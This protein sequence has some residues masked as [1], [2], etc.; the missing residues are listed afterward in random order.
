MANE[1]PLDFSSTNP[2]GTVG[3]VPGKE[4]IT[5]N[6]KTEDTTSTSLTLTGKGQANYGEH[7]QE[8]LLKL[9][10]NFA[11]PTEPS[12]ATIGQLWW[13]TLDPVKPSLMV[14]KSISP[15]VWVPVGDPMIR[16]AY[17]YE[18]NRM[19]ELYQRIVGDVTIGTNCSDSYGWGQPTMAAAVPKIFL[20]ANPAL[21]P[22]WVFLLNKWKNIAPV[23]GV[24]PSR[25][26]SD[27]FI[28]DDHYHIEEGL[29]GSP[30]GEAKGIATIIGEYES[31]KTAA[32]DIWVNRFNFSSSV[33]D[34]FT[35]SPPISRATYWLTETYLTLSFS[36]A[37]A[38]AL[39]L[40][41][42]T[43]GNLKIIPSLGS[44]I[45]TEVTNTWVRLIN[46]LGGG[47]LIKGCSTVD[48]AGNPNFSTHKSIFE[49]TNTFELLYKA[50]E[51]E[52]FNGI[53]AYDSGV[54]A[55]GSVSYDE[56]VQ[57]DEPGYVYNQAGSP[58]TSTNMFGND[59]DLGWADI[60]VDGKRPTPETLEIRLTFDNEFD[61]EVKGLLSVLIESSRFNAA[62]SGFPVSPSH[63]ALAPAA[64]V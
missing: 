9:L 8:N 17:N 43:G 36:W 26:D 42:T 59:S 53:G 60:S 24:D 16:V 58:G 52:V 49:L 63:P 31:A 50:N 3:S 37:D 34:I 27:G 46:G 21:N 61:E 32:N 39:N 13:K 44:I 64:F 41:F 48:Q 62:G 2:D 51:R 7:Q 55:T 57:Y 40:Y 54:A 15:N 47:I 18:Y 45:D 38:N 56:S 25:F 28:I 1:Y 4:R 14:L 5:V 33:L 23:V 10:E 19:V 11:S 12:N 29:P 30:A 22:N 6:P 20:P 35:F